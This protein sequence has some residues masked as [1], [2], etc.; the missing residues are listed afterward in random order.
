MFS[1][2]PASRQHLDGERTCARFMFT[3]SQGGCYDRCRPQANSVAQQAISQIRTVAANGQ[4]EQTIREYDD[5][6]EP[7]YK[8]RLLVLA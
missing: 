6:L 7:P 2:D 4:E 3:R 1:L 8:A 5:L